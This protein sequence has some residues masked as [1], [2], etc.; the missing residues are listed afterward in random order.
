MK[1]GH[2]GEVVPDALIA[3]LRAKRDSS[4]CQRRKFFEPLFPAG[5]LREAKRRNRARA[6]FRPSWAMPLSHSSQSTGYPVPSLY[7]A[8]TRS[9]PSAGLIPCDLGDK[10]VAANGKDRSR[11]VS[12]RHR[13]THFDRLVA[14]GAP[15]DLRELI[16]ASVLRSSFEPRLRILRRKPQVQCKAS[17]RP[18]IR[19]L[20][21][22]LQKG[23]SAED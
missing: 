23:L 6:R 16:L 20:R 18:D 13:E 19:R 2:G 22:T 21:E 8:N 12:G 4:I 5:V 10:G 3:G 14:N 9:R 1:P 15:L 7:H 11:V 17:S